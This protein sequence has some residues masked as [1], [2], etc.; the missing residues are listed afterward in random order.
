MI[1]ASRYLAV[2]SLAFATAAFAAPAASAF[3]APTLV[4]AGHTQRHPS[5]EWT[6]PQYVQASVVE[7]ARSPETASDG[8]FF[9]ENQVV[10]DLVQETDTQWLYRDQLAPG[11]YY[12]HVR[13]WDNACFHNDFQTECGSA[14]SNVLPL[15]ISPPAPLYVASV[16]ST[17]PAAIR[18]KSRNWTYRGDRIRAS[19]QD[20][21]N[22][23]STRKIYGVC[24]SFGRQRTCQ[25]GTLLGR[26]L[27]YRYFVVPASTTRKI[28]VSW[29]V[30]GRVVASRTIWA[31]E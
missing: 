5:A 21:R 6:L 12:V 15:T 13:G 29:L 19:F 26:S 2:A 23:A 8:S 18:D 28:V 11:T 27:S 16:K 3:N 31:Y 1:R 30:A 17:H 7:V 4:R 20:A 24:V 10:F 25:N 14:W 22:L 9:S